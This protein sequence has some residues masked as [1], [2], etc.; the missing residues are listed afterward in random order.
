VHYSPASFYAPKCSP[1]LRQ[2]QKSQEYAK[3]PNPGDAAWII[4]EFLDERLDDTDGGRLFN[5][6]L[7]DFPERESEH[8]RKQL[9]NFIR[10]PKFAAYP[11]RTEWLAWLESNNS[12]TTSNIRENIKFCREVTNKSA[13]KVSG[14]KT[15][16]GKPINLPGTWWYIGGRKAGW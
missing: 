5:G 15:A 16:D 1:S 8:L 2:K 3:P 7:E 11:W 4:N 6:I 9:G 12:S 14:R 13:A 10:R